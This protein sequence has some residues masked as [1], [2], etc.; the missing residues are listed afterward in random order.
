MT[1][2]TDL[3]DSADDRHAEY[4]DSDVLPASGGADAQDADYEDRAPFSAPEEEDVRH[5]EYDEVFGQDEAPGLPVVRVQEPGN[6]FAYDLGHRVQ[7]APTAPLRAIIWRGQ[8]KE[9][10]PETGLV[11]R[12][13][14]YR[15]NDGFWDCYREDELHAA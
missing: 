14:V 13:N 2:P 7:P 9:R 1:F 5:P 6:T 15:L 8:L 3:P 11:H 10:R 4:D 12:V